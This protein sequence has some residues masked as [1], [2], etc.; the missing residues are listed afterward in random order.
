[1]ESGWGAVKSYVIKKIN[2]FQSKV[3]FNNFCDVISEE[4]YDNDIQKKTATI[5]TK[6]K[7]KSMFYI[8]PI[9]F[10][11]W[12]M[13]SPELFYRL[14]AVLHEKKITEEGKFGLKK[15]VRVC[16]DGGWEIEPTFNWMEVIF[17]WTSFNSFRH[18]SPHFLQL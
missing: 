16:G 13:S 3:I 11:Y 18:L 9:I 6:N 12:T 4:Y 17:L 1:M 5:H 15:E 7:H 10:Y 8:L 14:R 2:K